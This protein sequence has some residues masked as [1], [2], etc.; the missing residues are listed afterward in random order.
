MSGFHDFRS[1]YFPYCIEKQPNGAWVV[2]NRQYKPVGFHT[3]DFINYEDHPIS[4][5][6][7]GLGPSVAKK[8][9]YTGKSEGDRIYLYNDGCIPTSNKANMDE[10]LKKLSIL[11]GLKVKK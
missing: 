7:L 3:N 1:I 11:A 10:Y 5:Q 8:L 9:S 6:L 2:L 4:T